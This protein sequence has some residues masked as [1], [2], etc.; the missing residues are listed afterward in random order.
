[1]SLYRFTD[2]GLA[3]IRSGLKVQKLILAQ[4][5][6]DPEFNPQYYI[7]SGL[8]AHACFPRFNK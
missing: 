3:Q 2:E 1:M 4:P 8:S 6:M 7:N 5:Y